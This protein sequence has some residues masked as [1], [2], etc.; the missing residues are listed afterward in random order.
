MEGVSPEAVFLYGSARLDDRRWFAQKNGETVAQKLT[1]PPL[2]TLSEGVR[3]CGSARAH[4]V[5]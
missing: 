2:F 5:C 3:R 1:R 4:H